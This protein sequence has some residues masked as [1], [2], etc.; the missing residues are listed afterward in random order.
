MSMAEHS[1]A[2]LS[3]P[4]ASVTDLQ[5][6]AAD[7]AMR[8]LRQF[9]LEGTGVSAQGTERLGAFPTLTDAQMAAVLREAVQYGKDQPKTHRW[10]RRPWWPAIMM[11]LMNY[12]PRL[13]EALLLR[14]ADIDFAQRQITFVTLKRRHPT[15]RTLP[16]FPEVAAVLADY[17]AT[18]RD[19]DPLVFPHKSR[20]AARSLVWKV[21][22]KLL[23]RAGVPRT[24]VHTLRHSVAT[25]L[26]QMDLA[27]ARAV[28]GHASLHST[29]RYV[30]AVRLHEIFERL[31][32]IT[33]AHD[34]ASSDPRPADDDLVTRLHRI[35][36]DL[37]FL[38]QTLGGGNGAL[39]SR[40]VVQIPRTVSRPAP[41][42][43]RPPREEA[44]FAPETRGCWGPAYWRT[45]RGRTELHA[46]IITLA[47]SGVRQKDI[48][49]QLRI[50][51]SAVS[52]RLA[53]VRRKGGA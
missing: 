31:T 50:S 34:S 35:E 39:P 29:T 37:A 4:V 21:F 15:T 44:D 7:E 6:Y 1:T 33:P 16:L 13:S 5:S 25:K 42:P 9:G 8:L 12:G 47:A 26:A 51:S 23:E 10:Q 32:P 49:K 52:R 41:Q 40:P 48:A 3:P 43:E 30:H 46:R 14:R 17:L 45:E 20:H 11:L 19:A 38:A 22:Q 28:L 36:G 24:R 27:T 18:R 53:K 2:L